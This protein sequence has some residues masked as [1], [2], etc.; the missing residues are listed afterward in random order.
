MRVP[1]SQLQ[2]LIVRDVVIAIEQARAQLAGHKPLP[3]STAAPEITFNVEVF[4]DEGWV[5][6]DETV[7]D[8]PETV[9]EVTKG[10]ETSTATQSA[11][12]SKESQTTK[13]GDDITQQNFGRETRTSVT[14]TT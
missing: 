6:G 7:A 12:V 5:D 8:T 3:I 10:A 1:L 11:M 2:E 9:T 14:E 13:K 4:L